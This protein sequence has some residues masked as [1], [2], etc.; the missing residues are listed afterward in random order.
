MKINKDVQEEYCDYIGR[1]KKKGWTFKE[2]K[3]LQNHDGDADEFKTPDWGDGKFEGYTCTKGKKMASYFIIYDRTGSY[4]NVFG[5]N[6]AD[7][8]KDYKEVSKEWD[9][10]YREAYNWDKKESEE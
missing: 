10:E 9:K 1:M 6:M 3:V 7:F 8:V 5:P 4:D 2:S